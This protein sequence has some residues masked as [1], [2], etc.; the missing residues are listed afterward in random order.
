MADTDSRRTGTTVTAKNSVSVYAQHAFLFSQ[1]SKNE[2]RHE[3]ES[4]PA[5]PGSFVLNLSGHCDDKGGMQGPMIGPKSGPMN[6]PE[7]RS[8]SLT[9]SSRSPRRRFFAIGWER[10]HGATA[11]EYALMAGLL[12]IGTIT[13]VSTLQDRVSNTVRRS[14]RAMNAQLIS[15]PAQVAFGQTFT[16]SVNT[17][18]LSSDYHLAIYPSRSTP[19]APCRPGCQDWR[20]MDNTGGSYG[21]AQPATIPK[22]RATLTFTLQPTVGAVTY[23]P[24]DWEFRLWKDND[25]TNTILAV[26]PMKVTV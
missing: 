6:E 11:V 25:P 10:E 24:G 17:T 8:A 26:F 15:A 5:V 18:D 12:A 16:V 21:G 14:G 9:R 2:A 3:S 13:A 4:L 22:P 7:V 1:L 23:P 20:Y 19:D